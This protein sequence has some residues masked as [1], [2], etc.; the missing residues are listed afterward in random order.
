MVVGFIALLAALS[1]TATALPGVDLIDSGDIKNGQVKPK[2]IGKNA[3][4]GAKVANDALTGADVR[5]G[6]LTPSDFSGSV[7]GPQGPRGPQGDQG[8]QGIQGLP[9]LSGL[10]QVLGTQSVYSTTVQ[11]TAV[12]TCPA[13]KRPL[14][15][16]MEGWATPGGEPPVLSNVILGTT[17]GSGANVRAFKGDGQTWAFTP[18]VV[19]A[20]VTP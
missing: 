10:Q 19:C 2:D 20:D 7:Q 16:G 4:N 11:K 3:V 8:I 1:G 15:G 17:D 14:S 5:D 12:A 18:Y 13:G 6:S 9:G